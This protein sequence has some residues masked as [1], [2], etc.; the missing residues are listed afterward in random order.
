MWKSYDRGWRDLV[1]SVSEYE[2][3]WPGKRLKVQNRF[4]STVVL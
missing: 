3:Q 4:G 1:L 2:Y